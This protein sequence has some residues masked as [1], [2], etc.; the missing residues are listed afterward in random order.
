MNI[1]IQHLYR[2]MYNSKIISVEFFERGAMVFI[3]KGKWFYIFN[4]D[5]KE[6]NLIAE[7]DY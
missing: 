2:Q 1:H 4:R 6:I 3:N 7:N 5:F